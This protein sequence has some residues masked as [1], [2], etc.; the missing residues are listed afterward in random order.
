M[1]YDNKRMLDIISYKQT[2]KSI[3]YLCELNFTAL[4][5]FFLSVK[6]TKN[7]KMGFFECIFNPIV[8][9]YFSLLTVGP[10]AD[11]KNGFTWKI[12]IVLKVR[13][14]HGE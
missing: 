1:S 8:L 6:L 9:Q 2:S 11:V 13:H 4:Q 12:F 3:L 7:E 5:Y 10:W 14:G